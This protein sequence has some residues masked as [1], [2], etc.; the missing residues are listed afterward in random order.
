MVD[1]SGYIYEDQYLGPNYSP[2]EI[3]PFQDGSGGSVAF[4]FQINSMKLYGMDF[5]QIL[6]YNKPAKRR[7]SSSSLSEILSWFTLS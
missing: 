2:D 7:S 1:P 6:F 3:L 5:F 4:P